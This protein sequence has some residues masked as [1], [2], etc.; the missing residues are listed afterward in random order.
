MIAKQFRVKNGQ[1]TEADLDVANDPDANEYF[2]AFRRLKNWKQN[3]D[4]KS[5]TISVA[6]PLPRKGQIENQPSTTMPVPP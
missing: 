3:N 1:K 2:A 5:V 6:K 4:A